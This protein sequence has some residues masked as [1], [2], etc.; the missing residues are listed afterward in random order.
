MCEIC[1]RIEEYKGLQK[2]VLSSCLHWLIC[3]YGAIKSHIGSSHM[4]F[5]YF[6]MIEVLIVSTLNR[7]LELTFLWRH[8]WTDGRTQHVQHNF[9]SLFH[10]CFH[11]CPPRL[12]SAS[13]TASECPCVI[14]EGDCGLNIKNRKESEKK[15]K[16][17]MKETR[18]VDTCTWERRYTKWD[19]WREHNGLG[20]RRRYGGMLSIFTVRGI[21]TE[22]RE[23]D[24]PLR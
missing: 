8:C 6:V 21:G 19:R 3:R 24:R 13:L 18:V 12:L 4:S 1:I 23:C 20:E 17:M 2:T 14:W 15:N 16:R 7:C 9:F 11:L 10:F 5:G 22:K